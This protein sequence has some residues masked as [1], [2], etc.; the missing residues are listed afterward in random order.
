MSY[1]ID[2]SYETF[3]HKI[4]KN[5]EVLS[6]ELLYLITFDTDSTELE[7]LQAVRTVVPDAVGAASLQFLEIEEL[8]DL[9]HFKIRVE[10][11]DESSSGGTSGDDPDDDKPT[12]SFNCGGG[13]RHVTFA[14]EQRMVK[15]SDA[16]DIDIGTGINWN[17]AKGADSQFDGVDVP[18]ANL[19]ETYTKVMR[20]SQLT[21]SFKRRVAAL[22][23]TVNSG[24][25]KGWDAGE[26]MFLGCTYSGRD[27]RSEKVSVNFN[28]A[29]KMN[30]TNAK[31]DDLKLGDVDGWDFVWTIKPKN[32]WSGMKFTTKVQ[33]GFVS[34]V[35]VRKSFSSLG[36]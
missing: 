30:E 7:A 25:F 10:Y 16:P 9:R 13:T 26:V 12:V 4:G 19:E 17:G 20:M 21:T 28:F 31:L 18:S 32:T 34:R 22:V 29:I 23:G 33:Y 5:G 11:S 6:A 1:I 14:L 15:S 35:V 2:E 3:V 27:K 24:S 8:L 36:L